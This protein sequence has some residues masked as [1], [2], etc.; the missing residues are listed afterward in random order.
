MRFR[1]WVAWI[2]GAMS[3]FLCGLVGN[4]GGCGSAALLGFDL[5][6][7]SFVATATAVTLVVHREFVMSAH[8]HPEF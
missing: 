5:S 6:K 1:G 4:Q 2:A 7:Q 8:A 3:G